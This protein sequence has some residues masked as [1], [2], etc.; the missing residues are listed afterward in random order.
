MTDI[1]DF[2][3]VS[4]SAD[5]ARRTMT[6]LVVPWGKIGRHRN[7]RKWRFARGSL[8]YGDIKY[9]RFND[10]HVGSARLGRPIAAEDTDAGLV[11]TFR[12]DPG[13]AGDRALA[14][15]ADRVKTGFS[16]EI[17][18]DSA[19]LEPD[20][21][22][23][24]VLLVRQA[25]LTG[26]GFVQNPA[27]TDARL[28]SMVA[29]ADQEGS[30]MEPEE[31]PTT[32]EETPAADPQPVTFSAD[33]FEQLMGRL[34]PAAAEE[35]PVVD[36]TRG[37]G[38][39]APAAQVAEPLP[40]RF[41]YDGGRTVF[42]SD[43]PH[44]FST[45]LFT[46]MD[47]RR[48]GEERAAAEARVNG[49][50]KAA[51]ADVE[52]ADVTDS[53]VPNRYRPDLWQPQQDLDSPLWDMVASGTTDGTKFDVPKFTSSSGLVSAATEKTEPAGGSYVA[54]LQTVTPTQVWG[55]VEI[56]RQAWRAGGTPQLSGILWDQMLRE[57]YEDRE[58]AVATFLA[59]LTSAT[60]I[61]LPNTPAT[62]PDNDD[63]Q[64]TAAALEAAIAL[65]QFA[66]GGS[67]ITS[68]AAH[69]DLF[70]LLARVKDDA[71]RPMYPMISP[72]NANGTAQARYRTMNIAGV[73]AVGAAALG[74]SGTASTNSW[75]FDPSLVRG[76]ASAPE[77]LFWD[78]GATVQTANIP[79]LSFVTMG[80]YGDVAFAN[81]NIAGVRQVVYDPS[82]DA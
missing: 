81:I 46:V 2:E 45:D 6:A 3:A 42:R 37:A 40:Y 77:R 68:F 75:L 8:V 24:G 30:G 73:T 65:L 38:R 44:D 52:R 49:M 19:D 4:F 20:P 55:K 10:E 39:D 54:E 76:W 72:Q 1:L 69:Q 27:F 9:I 80:I 41:S 51:F 79:Q 29:S 18:A 43:A 74:S 28:L 60:D 32:T 11:I 16:P 23:P 22:N 36:P 67:R 50:I 56:T 26:V 12:V 66:R 82:E 63:D 70:K 71:G 31:T 59:T 64:A 17:E 47:S 78:F 57:Y 62:S 34:T 53:T 58:A 7:G 48:P 35:R 33:Q 15:A 13:P 14:L 21:D 25:H 61:T 5:M